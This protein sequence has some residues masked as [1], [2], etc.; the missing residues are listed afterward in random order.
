MT[1]FRT[2]FL[3]PAFLLA[4]CG[5]APEDNPGSLQGDTF[6]AIADGEVVHYTGT[7][8]FWGGAAG[9]GMATYSTPDNPG[10]SEFAVKRFAGN[11]G[12]GISGEVD[13]S[14]FDLTI[15][16]GECSDGMSDR[17]YPYTATLL[18]GSEQRLGCAWTDS[19]PYSGDE[20]P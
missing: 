2:A 20:A 13:G 17:S 11:N 8:P 18:L 9:G 1:P 12:L 5:D 15:T 10:G 6:D 16:P 14:A 19:Q 4:A 3:L 7:E